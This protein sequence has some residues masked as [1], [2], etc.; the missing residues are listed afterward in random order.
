MALGILKIHGHLKP[1][2][3]YRSFFAFQTTED[4]S[5]SSL[6]LCSN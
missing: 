4:M 5:L 3:S 1:Q 6:A 2:R